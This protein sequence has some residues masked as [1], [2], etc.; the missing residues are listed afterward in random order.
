MAR[1]RQTP[2]EVVI[3][4]F[5]IRPLARELDI[6]PTTVV[7]WRQRSGLVPSAYHRPLLTLAPKLGVVLTENDLIHGRA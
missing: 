7:R 6:D 2:A 3:G 4:L 5:G 1:K